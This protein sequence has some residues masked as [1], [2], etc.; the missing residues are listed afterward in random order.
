MGCVYIVTCLVNGK[1][2]IG[3]TVKTKLRRWG[4]HKTDAFTRLGQCKN[5]HNAIRKYGPEAFVVETLCESN[6]AYTLV[7]LEK[8]WIA[9]LDSQNRFVGFNLTSGGD[10]APNPTPE[11]REQMRCQMA[12]NTYRLGLP[13]SNKGKPHSVEQVKKLRANYWEKRDNAIQI[14]SML[15]SQA[16]NR[17]GIHIPL[18]STRLC[19]KCEI[20][21]PLSLE[22]FSPVKSGKGPTVFCYECKPCRAKMV[23]D[24][25]AKNRHVK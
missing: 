24:R 23:R 20:D 4:E 12:G 5:F 21:K 18:P 7:E 3:K 9:A 19:G 13:A 14:K 25:R 22:N 1:Y 6:C 10:G 2:Y 16:G 8:L 17:K 15:R 11:R